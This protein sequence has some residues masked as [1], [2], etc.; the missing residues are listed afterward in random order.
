[1][2]S[3]F[4]YC[5]YCLCLCL[6]YLYYIYII[7][8]VIVASNF[9]EKERNVSVWEGYIVRYGGIVGPIQRLSCKLLPKVG[10][11][12]HFLHLLEIYRNIS[13]KPNCA[14]FCACIYIFRICTISVL[15]LSY[16]FM[17]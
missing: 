1:M 15:S 3:L 6:I 2:F 4:F 12:F 16:L 13:L 9:T 10:N 14:F 17:S 8:I 5:F 11:D 7:V